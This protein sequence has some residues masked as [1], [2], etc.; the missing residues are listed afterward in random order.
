MASRISLDR[1]AREYRSI[2]KEPIPYIDAKPDEAN[3]FQWYF[4]I[5]GP[6]ST[7]YEGGQYFGSLTY[8]PE[9]PFKPPSIKMFTPSGRFI[10]YQ[11]ICLSISNYHP[12]QWNPSWSTSAILVGLL[13]FMVG[14]DHALNAIN[15]S[16]VTKLY[17][18]TKS[19]RFNAS[20]AE[21]KKFFPE[22]LK[23]DSSEPKE[24]TEEADSETKSVE[25]KAIPETREI[26]PQTS[27]ETH[28]VED[29]NIIVETHPDYNEPAFEPSP[30]PK[31]KLSNL[32]K[33]K[34]K[35]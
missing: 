21:F 15:D 23:K 8:P 12:E 2:Q 11:D 6:P 22:L 33:K 25:N 27:T 9:Y 17:Y 13:S 26:D 29:H 24:Q 14:N 34:Q 32:F 20:N 31:F 18:A 19:H 7:P 4:V 35:S 16:Y 30:K 28:S 5:T 3:M 1:L 10:T